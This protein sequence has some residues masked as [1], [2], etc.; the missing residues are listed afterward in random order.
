[1]GLPRWLSGKESTCQCRRCKRYA[2]DP[3]VRK[4]SQRK[5]WQPTPVFL[6]GESHGQR[7]L[8]GY[9][10][11]GHQELDKTEQAKRRALALMGEDLGE[12]QTLPLHC[13]VT[14]STKS[15]WVRVFSFQIRNKDHNTFSQVC[16]KNCQVMF[17]KWFNI[18][19]VNYDFPQSSIQL[20]YLTIKSHARKMGREKLSDSLIR[21]L[22]TKDA[23]TKAGG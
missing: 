12:T 15:C 21:L 6:P 19:K 11:W 16:C 4:I 23:E 7:S 22:V 17:W 8:V 5:K 2:F 13:L 20:N 14:L 10:P 3:W 1:M 18:C 9:S